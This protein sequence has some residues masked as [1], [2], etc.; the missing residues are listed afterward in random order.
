[1]D[2]TALR[3]GAAHR[4]DGLAHHLAAEDVTA[5]LRGG[6][7]LVDGDGGGG[8]CRPRGIDG[9]EVQQVDEARGD[10]RVVGVRGGHAPIVLVRPCRSGELA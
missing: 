10:A 4:G 7:P 2:P 3:D 5:G 9:A 1:M 6:V 8:G